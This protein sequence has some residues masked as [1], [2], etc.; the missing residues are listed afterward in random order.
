MHKICSYLAKTFKKII[1]A[2]QLDQTVQVSNEQFQY[3]LLRSLEG[4]QAHTCTYMNVTF[5]R[6]AHTCT[7]LNVTF[8][9]VVV[10]SNCLN[11]NQ[12]RFAYKQM[13]GVTVS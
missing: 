8:T 6:Q 10:G 3:V 11:I 5:T 9:K 2:L 7:Y 1:E 13:L 4:K 12:S